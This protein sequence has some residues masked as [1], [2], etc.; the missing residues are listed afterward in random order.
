VTSRPLL[1][2]RAATGDPSAARE[3]VE[4][5]GGLVWAL[6][7]RHTRSAA[8]AEDAAQEIFLDVWRSAPRFD[9][10]RSSEVAFVAMVAR[11]RLIDLARRRARREEELVEEVVSRSPVMEE[12]AVAR[13]A[14]GRLD[15]R[16]REVLVLAA[17]DGLTQE[18]IAKEKGLPLGTV[19][20]IARRGLLRMR[21]L[22]SG[23]EP[24]PAATEVEP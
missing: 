23:E 3:C 22:L 13:E 8:D 1:L 20:T 4:R 14:L 7:R 2:P 11:R 15:A 6:A 21:A 17:F 10:E 24:A 12:S 19:K 18:E 5:F 9:P 16:E